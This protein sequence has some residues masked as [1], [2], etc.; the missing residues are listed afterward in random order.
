MAY[1]GDK[2]RTLN[3]ATCRHEHRLSASRERLAERSA[4]YRDDRVKARYCIITDREKKNQFS[5]GLF[6]RRIRRETSGR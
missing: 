1:R 5:E 4:A 6:V 3:T 2:Q